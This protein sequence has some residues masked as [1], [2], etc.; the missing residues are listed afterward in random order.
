M[1]DWGMDGFLLWLR[2]F[3]TDVLPLGDEYWNRCHLVDI[4][5]REG[6]SIH[7]GWEWAVWYGII[8][9]CD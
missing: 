7:L 4:V 5:K 6:Y 2:K 9:I 1:F 8:I 3:V